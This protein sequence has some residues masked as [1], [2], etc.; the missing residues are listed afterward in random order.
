[1]SEE[2]NYA[3]TGGRRAH[4]STGAGG[5]KSRRPVV[6]QVLPSLWTGGVEQGTV[7]IAEAIVKAGGVALV[8]S[9][10]GPRAHDCKRVG[11][12][13]LTIP[14]HSKN[15]FVMRRNVARLEKIIRDYGV[16]IVHARSRA[17]AW[18]ARTAAERGGAHFVTTFHGAYNAGNALKRTYNSIMATGERVIAISDFIAGHLQAVY[19]VQ[20]DRIRVI[21]RGIDLARFDPRNVSAERQTVLATAWRLPDGEPVVLLPGRL[22]R[23]K[24]QEVMIEAMALLG[25][26][27]LR[28]LLVGSDQG[29]TGYRAELERRIARND[30]SSIV[31][32]V[33]HC[34]D[35]PAVYML[36]DVVVSASTDPEAFGRVAA[37]AH[38]MG[39]PVVATD[40][41]G[42]RE[43]VLD[44]V[45][46]ALV[47]PNDAAA[48]AA[49]IEAA[50]S[51]SPEARAELARTAIA[52]VRK[53]FT[54]ESM[55]RKTLAVYNEVLDEGFTF[56]LSDAA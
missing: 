2:D 12:R 40:H 6:L 23:W 9:A 4:P 50:L 54:K 55:C 44:G 19:G 32:I 30:L 51:L 35:M 15:P 13:H 47:P 3:A 31:Q 49:A 33:D 22:T 14:A 10:G 39:R 34:A 38:A 1:M 46:G 17:P 56:E 37:E 5:A 48:L 21:P 26:R 28:C 36:S 25:R 29:R 16:D 27:K 24:G 18:S 7:D 11:A 8:A 45:T 41:G 20:R 52:H 53:N 42:A 43:T